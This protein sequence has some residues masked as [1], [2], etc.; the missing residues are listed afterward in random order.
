VQPERH[1]ISGRS[2]RRGGISDGARAHALC[3]V[4]QPCLI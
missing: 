2:R 3:P 1:S 4:A